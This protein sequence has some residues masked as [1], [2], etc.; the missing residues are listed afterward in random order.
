MAVPLSLHETPQICLTEGLHSPGTSRTAALLRTERK[1]NA[2]Y[3]PNPIKTRS[4][5]QPQESYRMKPIVAQM[6]RKFSTFDVLP[7]VYYSVHDSSP[8]LCLEPHKS[9]PHPYIPLCNPRTIL[10]DLSMPRSYRCPF[11]FGFPTTFP[12][13]FLSSPTCVLHVPPTWTLQYYLANVINHI[14]YIFFSNL[15]Q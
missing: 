4:L 8:L 1:R 3:K 5:D 14:S 12:Y 7:N 9:N 2:L 15:R 11:L 6:V 13:T 10:Y